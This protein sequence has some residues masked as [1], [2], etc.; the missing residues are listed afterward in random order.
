[1]ALTMAESDLTDDA[2]LGGQLKL[3]QPRAGY[4]AGIDAVLLAAAIPCQ[5][6]RPESILDAGGGV[7]TVGLSV[8]RRCPDATAVLLE[9]APKLV[10]LAEENV[11]R[12]DLSKRVHV[13]SGDLTASW[14]EMAG[15][16]L[17][18]ESF[19]HVAANPPFHIDGKGTVSSDA[20]KSAAHSMPEGDL[21]LWGRLMARMAVSG[22]T[23]T[24]IH[25]ADAL[26]AVL[27]AL[28][29]RFGAFK[30]LPIY[31]REGQPAIRFIVQGIKGSR[32]PLSLL[33]GL[34]LHGDGNAFTPAAQL[35]LRDGAA[36]TLD[37]AA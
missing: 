31:P 28:T 12:N 17:A 5:P 19:D 35:I 3:L 29:G 1:M 6:G 24:M 36:L 23:A 11:R 13:F 20:W 10:E 37:S 30:V 22:G 32:A 8:V 4:R 7:G 25:K 34:I 9:R 2:F 14:S 18:I 15:L 27:G 26:Q 16:G 21:D 33:P